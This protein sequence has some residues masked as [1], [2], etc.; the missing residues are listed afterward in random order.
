MAGRSRGPAVQQDGD[1]APAPRRLREDQR[2]FTHR[3][4]LDA[5]LDVFHAKGY[6]AATI[7]EIVAAAGASR[8]TFYTHF[9]S[10]TALMMEL[11]DDD[12]PTAREWW[13]ELAAMAGDPSPDAL[14][15]WFERAL[16]WWPAHMSI[17]KIMAQAIALEPEIA[18]EFRKALDEVVETITSEWSNGTAPEARLRAQLLFLQFMSFAYFNEI[19]GWQHGDRGQAAEVLT[20][21]WLPML[22]STSPLTSRRGAP[23]AKLGKGLDES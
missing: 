10:K 17:W 22:R 4:L 7:D 6:A 15:A 21:M 16:G 5:A 18:E 2:R 1:E 9:K 23:N 13:G 14:R 8:A 12:V 19:G 20:E 3:R 11:L